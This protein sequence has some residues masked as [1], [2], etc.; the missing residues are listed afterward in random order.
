MS[1][2][3]CLKVF[4]FQRAEMACVL[5]DA[6]YKHCQFRR[7]SEMGLGERLPLEDSCLTATD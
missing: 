3:F 4:T 5:L 2:D 6:V 7:H 1:A